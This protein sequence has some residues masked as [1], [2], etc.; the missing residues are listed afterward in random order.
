MSENIEKYDGAERIEEYFGSLL[1]GLPPGI[2]NVETF[3]SKRT[4]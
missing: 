1:V 2:Q 4:F 3:R